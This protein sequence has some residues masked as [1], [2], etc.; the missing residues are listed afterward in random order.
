MTTG[1]AAFGASAKSVDVTTVCG[2]C[3]LPFSDSWLLVRWRLLSDCGGGSEKQLQDR[4][5]RGTRG[6]EE[7]Q[8]PAPHSI[9]HTVPHHVPHP[10]PH[11]VPQ[12]VA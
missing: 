10:M 11:S 3:V 4:G 8:C 6:E 9:P 2:C 1:V 7:C 5:L 12:N